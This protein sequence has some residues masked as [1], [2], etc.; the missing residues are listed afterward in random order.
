MPLA[1]PGAESVS[2]C[3]ATLMLSG[4]ARDCRQRRHTGRARPPVPLTTSTRPRCCSRRPERSDAVAAAIQYRN[5]MPITVYYDADDPAQAVLDPSLS[6]GVYVPLPLGLVFAGLGWAL[7]RFGP[8]IERAAA[9]P[10][11]ART[12]A[13]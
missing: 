7:F 8:A 10:A 13:L 2:P 1:P 9:A 5:G 11:R 4:F 3:I 6:V 12:P